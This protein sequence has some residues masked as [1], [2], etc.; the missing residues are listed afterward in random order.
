MAKA[1]ALLGLAHAYYCLGNYRRAAAYLHQTIRLCVDSGWRDGEATA[2]SN[3]GSTM[4][5]LGRTNEAVDMLR[6]ALHTHHLTGWRPGYVRALLNLT[7]LY[8]ECGRL[9]DAAELSGHL[10]ALVDDSGTQASPILRATAAGT[11]GELYLLLGRLNE[12]RGLLASAL[13]TFQ[14]LGYRG[15]EPM[16]TVW[17]ARAEHAAGHLGAADRVACEAFRLADEVGDPR[18][19]AYARNTL[20]LVRCAQGRHTEATGFH[21]AALTIAGD[22]VAISTAEA[23]VGLAATYLGRGDDLAAISYAGRAIEFARRCHFTLCEGRA[24]TTIAEARLS[25]NRITEAIEYGRRALANHQ[26]TGHRLG[27]AR[28]YLVLSLA[29]HDRDPPLAGDHALAARHRYAE[30]GAPPPHLRAP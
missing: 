30:A 10:V 22:T 9:R 8:N 6:R 20:G 24:L 13:E 16:A 3:L 23:L 12:A 29:W 4:Q 15:L 27:E 21:L 18:S 28:A 25:Q 11:L 26:F 5:H 14:R 7:T 19:R 2:C 1:A 17:L